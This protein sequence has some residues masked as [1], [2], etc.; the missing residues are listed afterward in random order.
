MKD[1]Q[2]KDRRGAEKDVGVVFKMRVQCEDEGCHQKITGK[3]K[4]SKNLGQARIKGK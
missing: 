2:S 4:G 1:R 3:L